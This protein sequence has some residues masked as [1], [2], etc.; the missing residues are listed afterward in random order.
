MIKYTIEQKVAL[1]KLLELY[2]LEKNL[3][4]PKMCEMLNL[5]RHSNSVILWEKHKA[6]PKTSSCFQIERL[7]TGYTPSIHRE[8][9]D[10]DY[11]LK[12]VEELKANLL[13]GREKR[14]N[15]EKNVQNT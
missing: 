8:V 13:K 14:K 5:K 4:Y 12:C 3:S 2:R 11:I 1:V 10:A 15:K 9:L 7:I 6:M